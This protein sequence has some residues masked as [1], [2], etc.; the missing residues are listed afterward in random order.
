MTEQYIRYAAMFIII[1]MAVIDD[2]RRFKVSNRIIIAGMVIGVVIN[3]GSLMYGGDVRGYI[4]GGMA[5]FAIMYMVYIFGGVGAGDV[6]LLAV[7]GLLIGVTY[8]VRLICAAMVCGVLRGITLT[9]VMLTVGTCERD[10]YY[11]VIY[12]DYM[13]KHY[14]RDVR[15]LENVRNKFKDCKIIM[16]ILDTLPVL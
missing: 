6:K 14:A 12:N 1:M 8:I 7:C 16:D 9:G 2:Y 3:M 11:M 13:T 10:A 4:Y 5:G 15:E